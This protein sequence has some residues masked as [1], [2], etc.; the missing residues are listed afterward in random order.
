MNTRDLKLPSGRDI[1]LKMPGPFAVARHLKNQKEGDLQPFAEL[2]VVSAVE[3]AFKNSE[4]LDE[5]LAEDYADVPA[6][7]GALT[8]MLTEAQEKLAP[9]STTATG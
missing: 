2:I 8:E 4:V 3:P 5:W 6:L 1:S 7:I 9:L